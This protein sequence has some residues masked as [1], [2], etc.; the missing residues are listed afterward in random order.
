M[1]LA[2]LPPKLSFGALRNYG[3]TF[4]ER[5]NKKSVCI[6]CE[7]GDFHSYKETSLSGG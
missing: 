7:V 2:P 3:N 5:C 1:T 6:S 4:L